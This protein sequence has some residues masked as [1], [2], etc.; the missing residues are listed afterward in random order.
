MAQSSTVTFE[1]DQRNLPSSVGDSNAQAKFA[2]AV[3]AKLNTTGAS[4]SKTD[5]SFAA[6]VGMLLLDGYIDPKAPTFESGFWDVRAESA[7]TREVPD[8]KT[9]KMT[10]V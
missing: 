2:D 3:L 9:G 4:F 7:R 10:T 8:R 6:I 5:A 1:F